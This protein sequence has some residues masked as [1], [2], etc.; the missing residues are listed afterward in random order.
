[1]ERD[2]LFR[3]LELFY[4]DG[5][6]LRNLTTTEAHIRGELWYRDAMY[7]RSYDESETVRRLSVI[8]AEDLREHMQ[9]N[10]YFMLDHGRFLCFV[11]G[12]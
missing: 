12:D 4:C 1:M 11:S 2:K 10:V 9:H 3:A 6:T 7:E 8:L 5:F